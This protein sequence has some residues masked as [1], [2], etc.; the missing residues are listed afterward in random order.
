[1]GAGLVP[2]GGPRARQVA[3]V[4]VRTRDGVARRGSGYRVSAAVVLTAA[5]VVVDAVSVWVRFEADRP[6]EWETLASEVVA[7][8]SV[9]IA[10]IV[11]DPAVGD[12]EITPATFGRLG[13]AAAVIP[14]VAVGF[15]RFKMKAYAGTGGAEGRVSGFSPGRRFG[16]G[17]V[18]QAGGH[19]RS[20]GR[21]A[22]A[23]SGSGR[24]AL[25]GYVRVGSVGR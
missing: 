8:E 12:P 11:I 7:S 25:G 20:D 5:H 19:P 2:G 3:E 17:L 23:R 4:M 10:A 6:G 16:G 15:P 22:G 13:E 21:A 24:V 1:M 14:V 18:E 9:D